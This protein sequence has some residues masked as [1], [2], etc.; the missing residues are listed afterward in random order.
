MDHSKRHVVYCKF[1]EIH[2]I[3]WN[4]PGVLKESSRV[5]TSLEGVNEKHLIE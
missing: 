2:V 4:N 1:V 5:E 3:N